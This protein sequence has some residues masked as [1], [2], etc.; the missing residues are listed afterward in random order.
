MN[1]LGSSGGVAE[2]QRIYRQLLDEAEVLDEPFET[3]QVKQILLRALRAPLGPS[4][5]SHLEDVLAKRAGMSH[6]TVSAATRE[7]RSFNEDHGLLD[8]VDAVVNAW[9]AH[10]EA[11]YE[12]VVWVA[13]AL[14]VYEAHPAEG[15]SD[16][17]TCGR[18][19]RTSRE[20]LE[21]YLLEEFS[22]L[23]I[24]QTQAK[25]REIVERL[26]HRYKDESF[27]SDPPGRVSR[28]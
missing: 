22:G 25:R 7:M 19:E 17:A 1:N 3:D 13:D 18:F 24:V 28:P 9:A 5:I 23:P 15:Y 11:A 14:H 16:D 27:F 20:E 8:M 2:Q 26:R 10:L 4:A 12:H 6:K 21:S